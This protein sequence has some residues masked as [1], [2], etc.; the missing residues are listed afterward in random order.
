MRT[1]DSET[2][3]MRTACDRLGISTNTGYRLHRG[4]RFPVRTVS[5][6]PRIRVPTADLDRFLNGHDEVEVVEVV[7]VEANGTEPEPTEPAA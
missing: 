5:I 3:S 4:D 1:Q 6:G 7:E 2:V